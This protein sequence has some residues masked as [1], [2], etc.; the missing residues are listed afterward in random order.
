MEKSCKKYLKNAKISLFFLATLFIIVVIK[1][2][3]LLEHFFGK[4]LD[5]YLMLW[6][7]F[8][9]IIAMILL[10]PYTNCLFKNNKQL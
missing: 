9:T 6:I 2:I 3:S 4:E 5:V 8:S 7:A 10:V 1:K